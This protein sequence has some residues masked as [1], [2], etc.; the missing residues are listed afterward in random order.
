MRIRVVRSLFMGS[1]LAACGGAERTPDASQGAVAAVAANAASPSD[2]RLTVGTDSITAEAA[3]RIGE[4]DGAPE[5][6]FGDVIAI[7]ARRD[8]AFYVCDRNDTS[9]RLYDA[10]GGFVRAI[11]RKGAGPA[12][13]SLC[14]FLSI[15]GDSVLWVGD[16]YNGRFVGFGLDGTDAGVVRGGDYSNPQRVDQRGRFWWMRI[17]VDRAV[18]ADWQVHTITDRSLTPL[19][20]L[21]VPPRYFGDRQTRPFAIGTTEGVY[22]SVPKDT[23]WSITP[24]DELLRAFPTAYRVTRTGGSRPA[25]EIVREAVPVRY[26]P[27]EHA[28]WQAYREYALVAHRAY[29]AGRPV[30]YDPIPDTKPLLRAVLGDDLGRIWVQVHVRA[31]KRDIPPRPS[32]NRRPLLTWR[33]RNTY[34]LFDGESGGYIGRVAFPYATELMTIRGDR[35]WLRE[36][37]E[38]GEQLIGVYDLRPASRTR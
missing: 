6:A 16:L 24:D 5:F 38:S 15:V 29:N 32:G 8:S 9:I 25:L 28:E 17:R 23:L 2:S 1:L 34:D 31:E 22:L 21:T 35:V 26:E 37:G 19:D 10:R 18:G 4:L 13:Y 27:A 3:F 30:T 36:E 11:G 12:E 20:S 7:A 33:E 14:H